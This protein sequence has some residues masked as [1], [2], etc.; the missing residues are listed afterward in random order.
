MM[1]K[2]KILEK[3]SLHMGYFSGIP[4]LVRVKTPILRDTPKNTLWKGGV[5]F[6]NQSPFFQGQNKNG[7]LR[8]WEF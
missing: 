2:S 5:F 1:S 7:G 6:Q 4:L 3:K 8:I